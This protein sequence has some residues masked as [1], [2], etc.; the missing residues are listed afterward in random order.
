MAAYVDGHGV[1]AELGGDAGRQPVPHA[2]VV[3]AAVHHQHGR[4]GGVA[5]LPCPD[6]GAA[7]IDERRPI[8]R[9]EFEHARLEREVAEGGLQR[10][11]LLPGGDD[12]L[13]E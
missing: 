5:P 8:G 2:A 13:A 12:E 4:V 6:G 10:A 1:A 11:V 7:E 9:W 3:P